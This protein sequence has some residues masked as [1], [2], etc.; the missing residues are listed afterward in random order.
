MSF[1]VVAV[2]ANSLTEIQIEKVE[3]LE[4]VAI[5]TNTPPEPLSRMKI[6][7]FARLSERAN[8]TAINILFPE[9]NAD[10]N[11]EHIR[12][13]AP[14]LITQHILMKLQFGPSNGND[15]FDVVVKVDTDMKFD[16][17]TQTGHSISNLPSTSAKGPNNVKQLMG[18]L[19][20]WCLF[21]IAAK[22][23]P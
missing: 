16:F 18:L 11:L 8:A 5:S 10:P 22:A 6:G 3:N 15:I 12:Q 17:Q 1:G 9:N 7:S 13:D 23:S 21:Q 19:K 20:H 4:F 2:N 14:G